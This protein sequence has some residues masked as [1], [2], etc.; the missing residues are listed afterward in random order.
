M[1]QTDNFR[2]DG[3]TFFESRT[4]IAK[5]FLGAIFA[6]GNSFQFTVEEFEIGRGPGRNTTIASST[7]MAAA[8]NV[9]KTASIILAALELLLLEWVE[10]GKNMRR[11]LALFLVQKKY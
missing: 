10:Q 7:T 6:I 8:R 9:E 2:W 4:E 3:C 11:A 1:V 5:E